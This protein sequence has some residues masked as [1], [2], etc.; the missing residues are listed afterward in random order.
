MTVRIPQQK[1]SIDK[2]ETILRTTIRIIN[3]DRFLNTSTHTI[4]KE[5]R[6]GI[7]TVYDYFD[8][9]ED[10][11]MAAL[12]L[13]INS[14]WNQ[15]EEMVTGLGEMDATELMNLILQFM[16]NHA[17][18]NIGF[19]KIAFGYIPGVL[20]SDTMAKNLVHLESLLKSLL[21]KSGPNASF[22]EIDSKVFLIVNMLIGVMLGVSRG[23]PHTVSRE[24]IIREL[25]S[26]IGAFVQQ[27]GK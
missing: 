10:I 19:V 17:Y 1:R 12:D 11:L 2:Y 23:V 4:A 8:S 6:V 3:E 16:V 27:G 9:K 21:L 26:V 22:E 20:E 14:V 25:E 24:S 7:G 18:Q 13:E 15:I 5:A